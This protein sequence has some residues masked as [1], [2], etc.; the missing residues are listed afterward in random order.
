MHNLLAMDGHKCSRDLSHKDTH[1]GLTQTAAVADQLPDSAVETRH[2]LEIEV[3]L[4]HECK[5]EIYH[6]RRAFLHQLHH[7]FLSHYCVLAHLLQ[8]L[9][10]QCFEDD[11]LGCLSMH[12]QVDE[13][14][15][16]LAECL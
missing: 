11:E 8:S 10:A 6:K 13:S 2:I 16:M 14:I 15:L 3:V 4:A 5:V 9:L 7:C 12:A 1:D